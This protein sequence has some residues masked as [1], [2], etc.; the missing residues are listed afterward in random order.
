MGRTGPLTRYWPV[1][2]HQVKKQ[3]ILG[4]K[5]VFWGKNICYQGASRQ[6]LSLRCLNPEF[7]SCPTDLLQQIDH[8]MRKQYNKPQL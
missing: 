5:D 3:V 8:W 6:I 4:K 7:L 2:V 1:G